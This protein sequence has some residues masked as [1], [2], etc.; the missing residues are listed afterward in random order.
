M[1]SM[2]YFFFFFFFNDTATTEIYTLS[3]HDALPI[4][5]DEPTPGFHVDRR[6]AERA[7]LP[8]RLRDRPRVV[9]ELGRLLGRAKADRD[10]TAHPKLGDGRAGRGTHLVRERD[11]SARELTIGT[12]VAHLG[13]DVGVNADERKAF[14]ARDLARLAE[15]FAGADRRAELTVDRAGDEVWVRVDLDAGRDAEPDR[16]RTASAMRQPS[17]PL[18]VVG[19][20][21]HEA[22][23][24]G[25]ESGGD[26]VVG[27]GVAV[28]LHARRRKP[29]ASCGLELSQ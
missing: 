7:L 5:P 13:T 1:S 17:E 26:L 18:D 3:L 25:L 9:V 10:A 12:G 14:R 19:A 22:A 24:A 29:G 28:Q 16:L 8:H 6:A 4:S 11:E 20:I 15:R 2:F 23:D 27:L 21:D